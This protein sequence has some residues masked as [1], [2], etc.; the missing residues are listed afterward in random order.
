MVAQH[1]VR[2]GLAVGQRLLSDGL[3]LELLSD[4]GQAMSLRVGELRWRLLPRP[5]ALWGLQRQ[6]SAVRFD[7]TWL[8][9]QPNRRQLRL[10]EGG[11]TKVGL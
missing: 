1:Q 6:R 3:S 8:G 5:K 10:L 4:R 9:F 7:G 2:G 11:K